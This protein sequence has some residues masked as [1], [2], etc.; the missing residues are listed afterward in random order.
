VILRLGILYI[1]RSYYY[2]IFIW[3]FVLVCLICLHFTVGLYPIYVITL[4]MI[5]FSVLK[6]LFIF[7]IVAFFTLAER[8]VLGAVHRRRGPFIVGIFGLLQPIADALK[9]F[10]KELLYP[11]R[12]NNFIFLSAP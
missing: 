11:L 1:F 12:A 5:L 3:C 8:K 4:S 6:I 9:L 7:V 10:F 2:K